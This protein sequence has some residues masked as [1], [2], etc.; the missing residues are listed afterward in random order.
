MIVIQYISIRNMVAVHC[1]LKVQGRNMGTK[2]HIEKH[3]D[4][5]IM[6]K[7]ELR[8]ELCLETCL[9]YSPLLLYPAL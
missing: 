3:C 7:N 5:Y 2:P 1:K 8:M 6:S 9:M 4:K